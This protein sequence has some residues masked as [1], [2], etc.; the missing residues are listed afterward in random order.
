VRWWLLAAVASFAAAPSAT[1]D[2]LLGFNPPVVPW[3]ATLGRQIY[4]LKHSP[5]V[6]SI[7]FGPGGSMPEHAQQLRARVVARAARRDELSGGDDRDS[8]PQFHDVPPGGPGTSM[9][10]GI[11]LDRR[12]LIEE[13]ARNRNSELRLPGPAGGISRLRQAPGPSEQRR[14]ETFFSN[15]YRGR[16]PQKAGDNYFSGG[17]KPR[18][19]E[20]RRALRPT[21]AAQRPGSA[22]IVDGLRTGSR[23]SFFD[24]P[25]SLDPSRSTPSTPPARGIAGGGGGLFPGYSA[26]LQGYNEPLSSSR[27]A[28]PPPASTNP[29]G[30]RERQSP[31][32]ARA[33]AAGSMKPALGAPGP[34]QSPRRAR[35]LPPPPRPP[36]PAASGGGGGGARSERERE[37][38]EL[39][40]SLKPGEIVVHAQS[41]VC[42][43]RGRE[44]NV[45][46]G[47][48]RIFL[49]LE[50][51]DGTLR[52]QA[53]TA[54]CLLTRY[55]GHRRPRRRRADGEDARGVVE[56]NQEGE[57][58]E[59]GEEGE[60]V[61]DDEGF[62]PKLD[63]LS[64]PDV[65]R[66]RKNK[67]RRAIR[68]LAT[69][70]VKLQALRARKHRTPY[71]RSDGGLVGELPQRHLP[72]PP[73]SLSP[74]A[75]P[76]HSPAD[77]VSAVSVATGRLMSRRD[78]FEAGE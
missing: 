44:E 51:E 49:V 16:G 42:R 8:G 3:Q 21:Q 12:K 55:F 1:H 14:A 62:A 38:Q 56:G 70:V 58:G 46:G 18:S 30:A 7:H 66:K 75:S 29:F 27:T 50:F 19:R 17:P 59:K 9:W 2:L 26:P 67:A 61:S 77:A 54:S 47:K 43:F 5:C 57:K 73:T 37:G 64:Q 10:R 65:W 15:T 34:A 60:D 52:E 6:G 20:D 68:K 78:A 28:T 25:R 45:I 32:A 39:V 13:R 31:A 40:A 74:H 71:P 23:T 24:D 33:R 53:S 63:S 69:D 36:N 4:R 72:A 41:G 11:P 35:P 48:A 76:E 22:R